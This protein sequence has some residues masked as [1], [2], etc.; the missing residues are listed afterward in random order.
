MSSS[1]EVYTYIPQSAVASIYVPSVSTFNCQKFI[2][3]ALATAPSPNMHIEIKSEDVMAMAS[4]L[5]SI[6]IILA[7]HTVELDQIQQ[8]YSLLNQI[9]LK[10]GDAVRADERNDLTTI[11]TEILEIF[12]NIPIIKNVE[13]NVTTVETSSTQQIF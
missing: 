2:L 12:S 13:E 9:D 8:L 10:S 6:L 5:K 3:Q 1:S 4:C 11:V 7:Q